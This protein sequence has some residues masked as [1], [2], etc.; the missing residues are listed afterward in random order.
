MAKARLFVEMTTWSRISLYCSK[1]SVQVISTAGLGIPTCHGSLVVQLRRLSS[2][3]K[4]NETRVN[5]SHE[6][7][8][9]SLFCN[10]VRFK[11]KGSCKN[12][13]LYPP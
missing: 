6:C 4:R 5:R 9:F 10:S 13:Y 2:L 8:K 12:I 3:I 7:C 1:Q 11:M